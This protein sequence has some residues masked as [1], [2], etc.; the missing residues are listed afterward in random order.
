MLFSHFKGR[1][2]DAEVVDV[3][4]ARHL[5]RGAA[6]CSRCTSINNLQITSLGEIARRI[7]LVK[8]QN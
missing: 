4:E 8:F 5:W 3:L 7:R 1:K 6:G 2:K